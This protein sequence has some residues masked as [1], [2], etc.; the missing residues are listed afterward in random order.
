MVAS[1]SSASRTRPSAPS[2]RGGGLAARPAAR[3]GSRGPNG[4]TWRQGAAH[5]RLLPCT[6]LKWKRAGAPHNERGHHARCVRRRRP[7][8]SC[9]AHATRMPKAYGS[10]RPYARRGRHT[11]GHRVGDRA[12][13]GGGGRPVVPQRP[14]EHHGRAPRRRSVRP[15]LGAG[16]R[17]PVVPGLP[18]R[19]LAGLDPGGTCGPV[20]NAGRMPAY[21]RRPPPCG[22]GGGLG[23]GG[24]PRALLFHGIRPRWPDFVRSVRSFG[25]GPRRAAPGRGRAGCAR[26][27][28]DGGKRRRGI[29]P[30]PPCRP[31][32]RAGA[33][34]ARH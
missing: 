2:R 23:Q 31:G 25:R 7:F 20:R 26:R 33:T 19:R 16:R 1:S 17:T 5:L 30:R 28:M 32:I 24:R 8:G 13:S 12:D 29:S 34:A 14:P 18:H 21:E 3:A 22:A 15:A 4:R 11:K 27:R 6:I 10:I 9:V